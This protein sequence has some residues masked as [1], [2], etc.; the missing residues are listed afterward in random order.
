MSKRK[1]VTLE[2]VR[3]VFRNFAGEEKQYNKQGDRNFCVLLDSDTASYMMSEGW[4]VK[5]LKPKDEGEEPQAYIKVAVSYK[6]RPPKL[7]MITSRGLTYLGQDEAE[8]LD[9]VDIETA[10]VTLNPYEW[11]VNGGQGVKAYAVSVYVKIVEDYLE[12]KWQNWAEGQSSSPRQISQGPRALPPGEDY[13][14]VEFTE[15][16]LE[17]EAA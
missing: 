5:F 6:N 3:L 14:D 9:H 15:D 16:Q 13:I 1:N 10:D 4:N 17:L 2:D 7:V 12:L 11:D 8:L